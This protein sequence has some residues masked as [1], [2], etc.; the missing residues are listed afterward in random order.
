MAITQVCIK[1]KALLLGERKSPA[2]KAD[3]P[4]LSQPN[5]HVPSFVSYSPTSMTPHPL[6]FRPPAP[7]EDAQAHKSDW[8]DRALERGVLQHRSDFFTFHGKVIGRTKRAAVRELNRCPS[9]IR[10]VLLQ[11][12]KASL[13]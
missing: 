6:Y 10:S 12:V 3:V 7:K 4:E 8:F 5:P 1:I 2:P 11:S 13:R 9:L